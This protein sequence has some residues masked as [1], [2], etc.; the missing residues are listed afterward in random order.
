MEI[1][2]QLGVALLAVLGALLIRRIQIPKRILPLAPMVLS[3]LI[4]WIFG[5]LSSFAEVLKNGTV[6]GLLASGMLYILLGI[7]SK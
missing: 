4:V 5:E 1:G 3:I 6:S 2:N 7:T